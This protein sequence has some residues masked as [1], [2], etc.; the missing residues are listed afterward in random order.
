[1]LINEELEEHDEKIM[2]E[3]YLNHE[4][5]E[6]SQLEDNDESQKNEFLHYEELEVVLLRNFL[7][8]KKYSP[9]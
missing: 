7:K 4:G 5:E 1:M 2:G 3:T 8:S 9:I 6:Q